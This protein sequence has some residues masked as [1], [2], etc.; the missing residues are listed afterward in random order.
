MRHSRRSLFCVFF[1]NI[2]SFAQHTTISGRIIAYD[3]ALTCLNGNAY[4]TMIIRVQN[5]KKVGS[6]FV[7]VQFSHPC[8]GIPKWLKTSSS[9]QEFHLIRQRES[10]A[11]LKEFWDCA[12]QSLREEERQGC[13]PLDRWKRIPGAERES[14]PFGADNPRLPIIRPTA[15]PGSLKAACRDQSEGTDQFGLALLGKSKTSRLRTRILQ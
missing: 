11:K 4:W 8:A 6:E 12:D 9:I 7:S 2:L 3:N 10:D 5:P 15:S 1:T 13:P 14:L